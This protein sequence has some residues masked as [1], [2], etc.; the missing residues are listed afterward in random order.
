MA[1]KHI[2]NPREGLKN[3]VSLFWKKIRS[4]DAEGFC[5]NFLLKKVSDMEI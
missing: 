1:H 5:E 3:T 2:L 4:P